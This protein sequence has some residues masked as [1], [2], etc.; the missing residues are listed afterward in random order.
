MIQV[1]TGQ[2]AF[3]FVVK[4]V[5]STRHPTRRS[6][7]Q[8]IERPDAR[9]GRPDVVAERT[10]GGVG[11][12]SRS[13]D[14]G[15]RRGPKPCSVRPTSARATSPAARSGRSSGVRCSPGI[16]GSMRL[17]RTWPAR[18][19]FA[20]AIPVLT[21]LVWQLFGAIARVG[22]GVLEPSR[23]PRGGRRRPCVRSRVRIG[24]HRHAGRGCGVAG[25]G[26]RRDRPAQRVRTDGVHHQRRTPTGLARL[27]DRTRGDVAQRDER[28]RAG[29]VRRG[30]RRPRHDPPRWHVDVVATQP[31]IRQL[32]RA[33]RRPAAW[34][35]GGR[36]T[37][38]VAA[39]CGHPTWRAA[40]P[41]LA[42]REGGTDGSPVL[43]SSRVRLRTPR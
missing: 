19:A 33:R 12:R 23:R 3:A 7:R 22:S 11:R 5:R 28:D 26:V 2:G 4:D 31:G 36:S 16:W 38:H 13:A 42:A 10:D 14:C 24:D 27:D 20:V 35:G 32:P 43:P 18:A 41:L 40:D 15:W 39:L 29:R 21:L 1:T 34:G 6:P 30:R 25:S 8:R 9:D 37:A 17:Y